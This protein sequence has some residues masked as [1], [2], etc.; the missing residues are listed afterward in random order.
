MYRMAVTDY[1]LREKMCLFWHRVFATGSYKL[2]QTRVVTSQIDMFRE[3][4]MGNMDNLLVQLSRNPAMIMWL[5]N[6]DNH[7]GS[8]NENYGRELARALLHGRRQLH[9][10]GHQGVRA[11]IHRLGSG[12]PGLHDDKDAQ[13]YFSSRTGT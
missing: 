1:P 7:K 6:Q 2:I 4:G 10:R 12:K 3:H 9:R 11:G 8:I 13:Q 5:D